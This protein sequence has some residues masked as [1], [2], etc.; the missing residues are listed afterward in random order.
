MNTID[1]LNE[2]LADRNM[3][4][5]ALCQKA[6]LTRATFSNAKR[7]G[8]QLRLDTIE[9]VCEALGI[10]LYEFFMTDKDWSTISEY[11]VSKRVEIGKNN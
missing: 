8:N 1:R 3:T 9:Q 2:I 6:G 5:N 11:A 10:P 7:R 4:L